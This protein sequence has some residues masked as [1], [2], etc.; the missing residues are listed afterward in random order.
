MKVPR[1]L[2]SADDLAWFDAAWS[3]GVSPSAICAEMA[4]R[5]HAMNAGQASDMASRRGLN[6][7]VGFVAGNGVRIGQST[8]DLM[9]KS[10]MRRRFVQDNPVVP[11]SRHPVPVGG[12]RMGM[13]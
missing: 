2:Y 7:P 10:L 13:S 1:N 9:Q 5:H 8:E 3:S 6:R 12:Y 4:R 11:G